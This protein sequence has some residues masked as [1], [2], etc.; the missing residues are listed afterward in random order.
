METKIIKPKC[1]FCNKQ[2]SRV[3]IGVEHALNDVFGCKW[4]NRIYK[5]NTEVKK[6]KI[7]TITIIKEV[8]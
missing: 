5:T 3:Y 8:M 4:C 6:E 2:L 7:A 1:P